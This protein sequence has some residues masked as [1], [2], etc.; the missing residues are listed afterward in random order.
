[1]NTPWQF[2]SPWP[3]PKMYIEYMT[4]SEKDAIEN[5]EKGLEIEES[6]RMYFPPQNQTDPDWDNWRRRLYTTRFVSMDPG[7]LENTFVAWVC[8][9]FPKATGVILE[10]VLYPVMNIE[11][12]ALYSNVSEIEERQ[13][14]GIQN[15]VCPGKSA[16]A[17]TLES[18]PTTE[19]VSE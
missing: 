8:R 13:G 9:Q 5:A 17:P 7:R 10:I 1:M 6:K 16:P 19:E 18:E 2:F 15:F 4:Y 11:K 3:G 14:G 12:A